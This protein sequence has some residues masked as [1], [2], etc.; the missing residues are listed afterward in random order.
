MERKL[1]A[2]GTHFDASCRD[3]F[4]RACTQPNAGLDHNESSADRDRLRRRGGDVMSY[5]LM[6]WSTSNRSL[7]IVALV[8]L[9][10]SCESDRIISSHRLPLSSSP[11]VRLVDQPDP[12]D[13]ASNDASGITVSAI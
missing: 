8:I 6:R 9:A 4:V 13:P 10:T 1:P 3:R 11:P 7:A 12:V 5:P 2:A